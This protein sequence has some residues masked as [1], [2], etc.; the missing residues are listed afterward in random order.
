M[1]MPVKAA[2]EHPAI[3]IADDVHSLAKRIKRWT[4]VSSGSATWVRQWRGTC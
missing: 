2:I 3:V 1:L 4:W